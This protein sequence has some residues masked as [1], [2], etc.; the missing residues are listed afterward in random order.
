MTWRILPPVASDKEMCLAFLENQ[1]PVLV[2]ICSAIYY[3]KI[4]SHNTERL[5]HDR[6]KEKQRGIMLAYKEIIKIQMV[7]SF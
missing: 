1:N 7:L 3:N 5:K 4:I 6:S 2:V